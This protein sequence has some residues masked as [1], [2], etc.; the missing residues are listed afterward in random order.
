LKT[1][2]RSVEI[3]SDFE[4]PF[5]H[6]LWEQH[7]LP[8]GIFNNGLNSIIMSRGRSSV[9]MALI[10]LGIIKDSEA[11]LPSYL[12]KGLLSPFD[13]QDMRINFYKLRDDLS[14]DVD[15]IRLKLNPNTRVLY[16]IHYFGFPQ[17]VEH[18]SWIRQQYPNCAI[19]EDLAQALGSSL[20]NQTLGTFGDYSFNNLIKFGAFPDG[21]VLTSKNINHS[22]RHSVPDYHHAA[23][24]A[25]RYAAMLTKSA[26]F[27][28][29]L[30][31][32]S[33]H[34]TLFGT[35]SRLAERHP[36]LS[37][38]SALSL[39]IMR[40]TDFHAMVSRRIQNYKYLLERWD[41]PHLF[42]FFKN[43][44]SL[45]CPLG[46]IVTSRD[47]DRAVRILAQAGVY[48]PVHWSPHSKD[49]VEAFPERIEPQQ[50]PVSLQIAN[51]IMMIPVD[52]R[53][54]INEMDYILKLVKNL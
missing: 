51:S 24:V 4:L 17:P 22:L 5:S 18:L 28:T 45:V 48:C 49:P 13:E 33:W 1:N 47:R 32:Q 40:R 26:Y 34:R 7:K 9:R 3:G 14:V 11:L 41:S 31:P 54:G 43:L 52:Q 36:L 6:L 42:P 38:A 23:Y 44:P 25:T 39:Y 53:Y 21:S 37:Y 46:F 30:I 12:F 15:D 27:K 16:L 2:R 20:I 50:F 19:I 10:D 8:A 29:H 35:A